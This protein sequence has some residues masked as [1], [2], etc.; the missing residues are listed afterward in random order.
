VVVGKTVS[1]SGLEEF[2]R[3][4]GGDRRRFVDEAFAGV[5]ADYDRLVRLFSGGL[6]QRWRQACMD[7][8]NIARGGWILDCATGTGALAL[9]AVR[10]VGPTGRVVGVDV[11]HPMLVEA[12]RKGSKLSGL[13]GWVQAEA[14]HL[15]LRSETVSTITL[16]LSLRHMEIKHALG[17]MTRVL[18]PGGRIALLEFLRPPPGVI[19]RIALAYL[20]WLV[21]P[22]AGLVAW[23]RAAWTLAAYL[24]RTIEAAPTAPGLVEVVENAGLRVLLIKSLFAHVVWL[25]V[26]MKPLRHLNSEGGR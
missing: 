11:C 26:A 18:A 12:R 24:P 1:G 22:L 6:D 20:R 3:Q 21:P 8:C 16:G 9:A 23:S 14:E 15:P 5:A 25:A 10:Q 17:E 4:A 19:P 2:W 13:P 7:A